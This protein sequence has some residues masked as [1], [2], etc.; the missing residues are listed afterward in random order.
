MFEI[1]TFLIWAGITIWIILAPVIKKVYGFFRFLWEDPLE[2]FILMSPPHPN[3]KCV[4]F[5]FS[6]PNDSGKLH[7]GEISDTTIDDILNSGRE[8][9]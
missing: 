5:S 1:I 9:V 6:I 4:T 8:F 2:E 7:D 3:C